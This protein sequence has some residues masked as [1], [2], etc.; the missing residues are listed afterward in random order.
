MF[1]LLY[2]NSEKDVM[3]TNFLRKTGFICGLGLFIPLISADAGIPQQNLINFEQSGTANLAQ[4]AVE[5]TPSPTQERSLPNPSPSVNP[6]LQRQRQQQLRLQE[7]Q[8]QQQQRQRVQEQRQELLQQRNL[9]QNQE[10]QRLREQREQQQQRQRLQDQ[11][12]LNQDQQRQRLQE[13]GQ[14]LQ[15]QRQR[16]QQQRQRLQEQQQRQLTNRENQDNLWTRQQSAWQRERDRDQ[17]NWQRQQRLSETRLGRFDTRRQNLYRDYAANYNRNY[18]GDPSWRNRNYWENR[19]YWGGDGYWHER[20]YWS[21]RGYGWNDA[22]GAVLTG[23]VS[24]AVSGS[25]RTTAA[26]YPQASQLFSQGP[27]ILTQNGLTQAACE[28]GNIVVLLP[29]KQVMCALSNEAFMPGTY[30]ISGSDLSLI[31]AEITY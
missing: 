13:Q 29:N 18:W 22:L 8:R 14:R 12:T 10:Q 26:P 16:L 7:Q 6:K 17:Y 20:D 23:L 25:I 27:Q 24:G 30:Q 5:P 3:K 4:R 31:P 1:L 9:N 21:R 11:R 15:D 28:P 19:S 2:T